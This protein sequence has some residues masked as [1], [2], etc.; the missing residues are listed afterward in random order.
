MT[1][2]KTTQSEKGEKKKTGAENG[3][4]M[5]IKRRSARSCDLI[6]P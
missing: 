5:L 2:K 6:S 4:Q 1:V 3:H